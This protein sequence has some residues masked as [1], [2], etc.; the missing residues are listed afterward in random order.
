[1]STPQAISPAALRRLQ[2][3]GNLSEDRLKELSGFCRAER[4]PRNADPFR[5]RGM[6]GQAVY[7]VAGELKVTHPDGMIE[8][9]VGSCERA[10]WPLSRCIDRETRVAAITESELLRI[11]DH[12][13]DIMLMWEQLAAQA[14]VTDATVD[15]DRT[16]WRQMSA[17]FRVESLTAGAL[18]QL[19]PAHI[20]T[21]LR[22]FERIKVRAGDVIVREGGEGDYYYLIES[23]RC[24]VTRQVAGAQV[25]LAELR[26][27][28][29]FGEEALVAGERR[30]ATV[31]MRSSGV[32]LRLGKQ[33]FNELLREPLL[34]RLTREA[35]ERQVA[36][37]AIWLDV[38][39]PAE[40][41]ID[42]MAGAI[43]IPLAEIRNA[44]GPL[45][46]GKDYIVYCQS[47]R[48]SAAAAFI[49]SQHGYR[50]SWLEGGLR[51][52]SNN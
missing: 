8:V 11:D 28:D 6:D 36:A 46:I 14:D 26:P 13:L 3:L 1:M 16:D 35:A 5:L 32:L 50:A 23:G 42:R 29:A 48:R 18:S 47:G 10:A 49:L 2:P 40:F 15:A 39:F 12:V 37:G 9:M 38:R 45:D 52:A 30:N 34:R 33:D 51:G 24:D 17:A 25:P 21:L 43:N 44:V 20:D 4:V 27:G 7:L 22:R 19:P 31:T 41:Q